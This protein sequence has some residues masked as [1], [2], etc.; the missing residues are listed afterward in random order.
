MPKW[1]RKPTESWLVSAIVQSVGSDCPPVLS[2]G[3]VAPCILYPVLSPSLKEGH[4]GTGICPE[5][6]SKAGEGSEAQLLQCVA[7]ETVIFQ[8]GEEKAQGKPYCSL[9]LPERMLLR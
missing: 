5:K 2:T 4:C 1:P 3:E 8:S 7:E 9:Q 6:G